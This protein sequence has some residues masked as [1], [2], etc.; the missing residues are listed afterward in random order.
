MEK[1]ASR[2]DM[3]YIVTRNIK[4][5]Q[6]GSVKAIFLADSLLLVYIGIY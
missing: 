5:Y 2:K 1:V 6:N 4:D 3:D